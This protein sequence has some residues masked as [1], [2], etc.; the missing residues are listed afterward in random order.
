M[1]YPTLSQ[2]ARLTAVRLKDDEGNEIGKVVEWLMDVVE[3]KVIYVIA[4]FNNASDYHAIPWS[5]MQA[6]LQ[7]G[8]YKVDQQQV[9]DH[10]V[11][12]T[13]DSLNDVIHDKSF[14]DQLYD[15][16]ELP[17]YWEQQNNS[18]ASSRNSDA[19]SQKSTY[20]SN[21][22]LSEGKGYGG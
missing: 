14:L 15:T 3:G 20:Q 9:N 21:A 16:Y 8:G 5:L 13:R 6:D 12:I 22:E 18:D 7:G 1:Q 11:T 17:K 2:G 19:S 10:Q 4:E